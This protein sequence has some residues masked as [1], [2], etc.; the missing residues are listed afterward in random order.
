[1]DFK[2]VKLPVSQWKGYKK[3]RLRALKEESQAFSTSY[4]QALT[5]PDQKWQQRLQDVVDEKSLMSF[6][7]HQR[8]R[9]GHCSL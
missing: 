9:I 7:R 5:Y 6:D 8:T 4:T 3:I 2:V 1:M